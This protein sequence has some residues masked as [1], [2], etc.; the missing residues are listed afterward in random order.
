[1]KKIIL[2]GL[3]I[4][5]I[6]VL[7][8]AVGYWV[9][10]KTKLDSVVT[11][12]KQEENKYVAFIDEAYGMIMDNYWNK[13]SD[14]QLGNIF[15]LA[16]E[17]LTGK[18]QNVKTEDKSN[19][20]KMME[21]VVNSYDSDD[22]KKQFSTTVVDTVLAN[23]EPFGRSRLY[24]LKDE[25]ALSDTVQNK[26]GVDQYQALGVDKNASASAI[27]E[28][29]KQESKKWDPTINNSPEA[30]QKYEAVQKAY[31]VLSDP[32]AKNIYDVAGVEP[33]MEYKLL[34]PNIYYVHLTKFS[35]T[36]F[37]EL[38]RVMDKVKDKPANLDTLIFDLSGNV[39][40]QIDL[41][42]YMLGPFIGNDQYAYQFLHQAEKTD[43]KT[44]LGWMPSMVRYKKVVVLID[45]KSQSTAEL[46]ASV[47]K[48]YNVGVVVGKTTSGWG[49]VERVF[50]MTHQIDPS[51]KNS[52]FLV[53]TLT[54][55]EDGQVIQGKGVDP[56]IDIRTNNWTQEL[57]SYFNSQEIVDTVKGIVEKK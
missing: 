42:P 10:V 23:L 45:E 20:L 22:K 32:V 25:K 37:D 21:E 1:M 30:K 39:G 44:K 5:L 12:N 16:T 31:Q 18:P 50:P 51:E 52:L 56:V 4:L 49:T 43:Y 14:E 3:I 28:A 17:K 48:K 24:T 26:S 7:G 41:L 34:T 54:L 11:E 55:R 13:L 27:Q 53:H 47:L 40:G 19:L 33:T 35:P 15:V 6:F 9:T 2:A 46:M 29:Y 38:Q 8:S 36:S 57:Y